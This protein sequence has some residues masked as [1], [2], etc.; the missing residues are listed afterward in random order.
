MQSRWPRSTR[1]AE[2]V[3]PEGRLAAVG[4][5]MGGAWSM[6]S[7]AQRDGFVASVVY[8]GTIEGPS[9]TRASVPV[10]AHCAE[11]DPYESAEEVGK[12]EATL[13]AAGRN[14]TIHRYPG[15]GHWFAEPSQPAFRQGDADLAF[16]RTVDF[17][18]RHMDA[19][20]RA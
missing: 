6:W 9:L 11:T 2:R 1:L 16:A 3:G 15:T 17:I 13:K 7:P 19:A 8:Y 14:V 4:F 10:L 5:S 12:F 18:R 20:N